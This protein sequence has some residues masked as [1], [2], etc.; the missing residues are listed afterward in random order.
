MAV[1]ESA[2]CGLRASRLLLDSTAQASFWQTFHLKFLVVV[3]F[4]NFLIAV[5]VF[6]I[7]NVFEHTT[8][9]LFEF[10]TVDNIGVEPSHVHIHTDSQI[11]TI[12]CARNFNIRYAFKMVYFP[13][14]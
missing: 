10:P 7:V 14:F 9:D 1:I 5:L 2:S 13:Y 12:Y 3:V 8:G 6:R 11:N 4:V